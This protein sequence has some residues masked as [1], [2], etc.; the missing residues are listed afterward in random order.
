MYKTLTLILCLLVS[1]QKFCYIKSNTNRL[2]KLDDMKYGSLNLIFLSRGLKK[3]WN[4]FVSFDQFILTCKHACHQTE[5][6]TNNRVI[7]CIIVDAVSAIFQS[8]YNDQRNED[9]LMIRLFSCIFFL[10][11]MF[12]CFKKLYHFSE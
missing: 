12:C 8:S 5:F 9:D 3:H 2:Q 4:C 6:R 1:I 11:R 10:F 7:D